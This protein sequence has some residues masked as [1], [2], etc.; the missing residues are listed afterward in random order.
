MRGVIAI[1]SK[2]A[3]GSEQ[4]YVHFTISHLPSNPRDLTQPTVPAVCPHPM[5]HQHRGLFTLLS[6]LPRFTGEHPYK[7]TDIWRGSCDVGGGRAVCW[8]SPISSGGRAFCS[9]CPRCMHPIHSASCPLLCLCLSAFPHR[10]SP[11][12]RLTDR[13]MLS[14]VHLQLW[15]S[16]TLHKQ[17]IAR[18]QAANFVCL[19]PFR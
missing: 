7:W 2:A 11:P 15:A 4:K 16:I 12:A 1:K 14:A 3:I 10:S 9:V 13:Q 19:S 17:S 5:D 18:T 8:E 6:L